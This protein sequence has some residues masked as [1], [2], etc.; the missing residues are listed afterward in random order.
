LLGPFEISNLS[1][2]D[3]QTAVANSLEKLTGRKAFVTITSIERPP[4]YV[5][6]PVKNPGAYKY[7]PGMTVLH[8]VALAG[9]YDRGSNDTWGRVE[10]VREIEKRRSAVDNMLRAVAKAAVLKSERDGDVA[11]PPIRL[12]QLVS[13]PEANRLIAYQ[14]ERRAGIVAARENRDRTLAAGLDAAKQEEQMRADRLGPLDGL[15]KLREKRVEAMRTLLQRGTIN[16]LVVA[17]AEA[18]LVEVEQRR[19]DAINQYTMAKQR[20][21][22]AQQEQAKFQADT[23][24]EIENEINAAEQQITAGEGEFT[25]SEGVLSALRATTVQYSPS[26]GA[27]GFSYEIVR[28]K[29]TT[30]PTALPADGMATLQ[31]GDLVRVAPGAAQGL[32]EPTAPALWTPA[33]SSADRSTVSPSAIRDLNPK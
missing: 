2:T 7:V 17:Q 22:L 29:P 32:S 5:L 31:P 10:S 23:R 3:L 11:R 1:G 16:N 26:S 25:T 24:T 21:A 8:I 14:S 9:G 13:L 19:Q 27:G 15:I 28:Q 33:S 6:G 30:G 12:L 20:V 18:E 4:V